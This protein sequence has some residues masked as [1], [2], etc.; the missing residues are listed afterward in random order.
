M[1]NL[2]PSTDKRQIRAARWNVNLRRYLIIL[3]FAILFLSAISVGVY[4]ILMDTKANAESLANSH[5]ATVTANVSTEAE[6]SAFKAN[7]ASAKSILDQQVPYTKIITGVAQ[8]LPSGVIIDN[9]TLSAATLGTATTLQAHA[10]T[11]TA[12]LAI[13]PNFQ[14]S[15]LFSNV[16]VQSLS[17]DKSGTVSNYPWSVTI[18]L[19][20]NKGAAQ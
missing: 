8:A 19:T 7:L 9:L 6:A 14:K 18:G 4:V 1:I 16:S 11:D 15:P 20:I 10:K 17:Q 5:K 3:I 2:L 12:A 13:L